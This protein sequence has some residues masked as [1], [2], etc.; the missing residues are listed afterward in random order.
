MASQLRYTRL[1]KTVSMFLAIDVLY[2]PARSL[3][4]ASTSFAPGEQS[5]I[6]PLNSVSLLAF[7][8]SRGYFLICDN[9]K[10]TLHHLPGQR[11]RAGHGRTTHAQRAERASDI[12]IHTFKL[13]YCFD[14]P[15]LPRL[16]VFFASHLT[17]KRSHNLMQFRLTAGTISAS[18]LLI[19]APV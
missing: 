12:D 7:P 13:N 5:K 2:T 19:S 8:W 9:R 3:N 16:V 11:A 1:S 18:H 4:S 15:V 14:G 6:S 17:R 10:R